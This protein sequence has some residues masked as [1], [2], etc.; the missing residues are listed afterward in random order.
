MWEQIRA[1]RRRSILL[2]TGMGAFLLVLGYLAGEV[3]TPGGGAIG[4]VA[5]LII[6]GIQLTIA[7]TAAETILLQTV[8]AHEITRE[9]NPRLFNIVEEMKLASGLP[10]M[11]RIFLIDDPAPN[12]FAVGHNSRSSAIAVTTG[13]MHR[14]DRDELQGV[15]AHEIAHLKNHDV[16]FM[17]LAAI[18][19]G[20]IIMMSEFIA[21]GAF[22][23]SRGRSRSRSR[24]GG[25]G[26]GQIIIIL[27]AL[28]LAILGPIIAQIFY[29]ACSRKREYLADASAAQFTRYPE[30]LASALEK[31]SRSIANVSFASKATAPMFIVNPLRRTLD[32]TSSIF[33][34]HPPT[35]ERVRI[36]RSM[37]GASLRDYDAAFRQ[38]TGKSAIGPAS[39][40]FDQNQTIR[41]PSREGPI[42]TRQDVQTVN[43]R[44]SGYLTIP[45]DCGV[46]LSVAENYE[47]NDIR[48]IRCGSIHPVP[49]AGAVTATAP[50]APVAPAGP[51][52][53]KRTGTGWESFRCACGATIQLSPAFSA[54]M[55]RCHKCRADISVT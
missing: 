50:T 23:S 39:L 41:E 10:Y 40:R 32:T 44:R 33:S 38:V 14:L 35:N 11:P 21:R 37:T 9:D 30:G 15:I 48:C 2:I 8:H 36:L 20:S 17:T 46:E 31:V 55:V 29:F 42:S 12:A 25:S 51:L 27:I 3:L 4:I 26:Q 53:Y 13:L 19:L 22:W 1:N 24:G 28:L 6:L 43:Y 18:L 54:P 34:T 16:R 7:F 47:R 49:R 5:A 52:T 45:C